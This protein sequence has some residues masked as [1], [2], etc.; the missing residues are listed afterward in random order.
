MSIFIG[1]CMALILGIIGIIIWWS[2][3]VAI[4][5]GVIPIMLIFAGA[6]AVY[7]SYDQLKTWL[8]S[9]KENNDNVVDV[10]AS[11][12][13]TSDV[14]ALKKENE[15]LKRKLEEQNKKIDN[16][17]KTKP[18]DAKAEEDKTEENSTVDEKVK[19]DEKAKTTAKDKET[20]DEKK[21]A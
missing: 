21:Q 5:Q 4:L 1:G 11:T 7:L 10:E 13:A 3:F 6:L 20:K 12:A 8:D 16:A 9:R 17:I 2:H 19:T 14:D 15:E 18:A